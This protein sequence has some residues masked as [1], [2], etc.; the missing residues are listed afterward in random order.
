MNSGAIPWYFTGVEIGVYVLA[1]AVFALAWRRGRYHVVTLVISMAYGYF[2]EYL[3]IHLYHSYY[4]NP[5]NLM[6][7][8]GVPLGVSIAWGMEIYV[9]MRT[10]DLLGLAW[11]KRPWMDALMLLAI[12]VCMDPVAGQLGY[13][14]W[15]PQGP[16]LGIPLENF[17]GWVVI[18]LAFSYAWRLTEHRLDPESYGLLGQ[19]ATMLGVVAGSLVVLFA[20]LAGF[21]WLSVSP[22]ERV[23]LQA[24][25]LIVAVVGSAAVI[26]RDVPKFERDHRPNWV[27]L[28]VPIFFFVYLSAMV[29]TAVTDPSPLLIANALVTSVVGLYLYASPYMGGDGTGRATAPVTT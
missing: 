8:G 20:I 7:P 14:V 27:L 24:I 23:W 15:T 13:W 9:A 21:Q 1:I 18:V 2:L 4:Y 6:L 25:L 28:A 5:F 12:D 22:V 26:W 10:T 3:D 29:F 17:F 19:I 16:Y 11:H